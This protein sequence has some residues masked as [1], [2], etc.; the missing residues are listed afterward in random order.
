MNM[1]ELNKYYNLQ[2]NSKEEYNKFL[3]K[4]SAQT[5]SRE[6]FTAQNGLFEKKRKELHTKI[7]N[8][9]LQAYPAQLQPQ[10]YFILGSIGSGKTSLKDTIVK[11]SNADSFLYINF[12]DLKLKLPEYP[13][14]KKLKSKKGGPFRTIR[15]CKISWY[16]VSK[17]N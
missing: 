5:T 8:D 13:I 2:K 6:F 9:Y 3:K 1:S 11:G 14:L 16:S 4:L 10:A 17:S 15:I 7:I 12:D